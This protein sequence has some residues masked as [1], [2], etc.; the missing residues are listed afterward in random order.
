MFVMCLKD[1][2]LILRLTNQ[3][4]KVATNETTN[5]LETICT[6]IALEIYN[7]NDQQFILKSLS[8]N[9]NHNL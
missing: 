2:I 3:I 9:L 5:L 8:Q 6:R 4:L 1:V 7:N